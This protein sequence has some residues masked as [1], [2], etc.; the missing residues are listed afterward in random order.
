MSFSCEGDSAKRQVKQ[1]LVMA[2]SSAKK[3][4]LREKHQGKEL[5]SRVQS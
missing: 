4:S 1:L 2:W 3:R 5:G